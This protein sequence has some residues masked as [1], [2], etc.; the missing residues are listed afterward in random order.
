MPRPQ[1]GSESGP[2]RPVRDEPAGRSSPSAA[3]YRGSIRRPWRCRRCRTWL[4]ASAKI[5]FEVRS[6][7][8]SDSLKSARGG[9]AKNEHRHAN[10]NRHRI[11]VEAR[12]Q[13]AR[14]RERRVANEHSA[15]A[16]RCRRVSRRETWPERMRR[17]TQRRGDVSTIASTGTRRTPKRLCLVGS[18]RTSGWSFRGG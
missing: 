8:S 3:G 6:W 5:K 13:E 4:Q 7:T 11:A 18:Q 1:P 15:R 14:R 9:S 10:E 17:G 12:V 16:G 2:R